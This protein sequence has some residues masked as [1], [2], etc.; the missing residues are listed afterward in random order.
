MGF[1]AGQYTCTFDTSALGQTANDSLRVTHQLFR[2]LIRGDSFGQTVQE[3]I[4]QG[5]DMGVVMRL[6]EFNAAG[7]S[8]A[9]WPLSATLWS[10]G[11]IG[12]LDS[13]GSLAKSLVL[14]AIAGTPAAS[15]P[16]SMTFA[17]ASLKEN[18]PV[19]ILFSPSLRE[20]PLSFR[21]YP[22]ANGVFATQT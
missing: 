18:F 4:N 12:R 15:T 21:I 5:A 14:T 22:D 17:K 11:V 3:A 1:I 2:Q 20:V 8:K 7:A 16:A 19:D 9:F 6:M 10:M 13:A